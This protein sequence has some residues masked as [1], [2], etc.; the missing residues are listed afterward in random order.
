MT[1]PEGSVTTPVSAP[2]PADCPHSPK[3]TTPITADNL[4]KGLI[5]IGAPFQRCLAV[6]SGGTLPD[7]MVDSRAKQSKQ[8]QIADAFGAHNVTSLT[9]GPFTLDLRAG[10]LLRD[11][12]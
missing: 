10:R 6:C 8:R 7:C 1:A 3:E 2:V 4:N 5:F 9:F 12:F 11:Q